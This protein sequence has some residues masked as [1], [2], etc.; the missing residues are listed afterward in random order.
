MC[1]DVTKV[2]RSPGFDHGHDNESLNGRDLKIDILEGYI[3]TSE[4]F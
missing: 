2:V 4:R 3:R 1:F